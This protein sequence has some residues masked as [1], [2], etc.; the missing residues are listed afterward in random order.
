M[1]PPD[2][3]RGSA[4]DRPNFPVLILEEMLMLVGN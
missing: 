1:K 2:Y 3:N 4:D